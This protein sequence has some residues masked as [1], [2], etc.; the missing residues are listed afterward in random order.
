MMPVSGDPLIYVGV[1]DKA[2][3]ALRPGDGCQVWRQDLD[4]PPSFPIAAQGAVYTT[5]IAGGIHA[6]RRGDG[7]PLWAHQLATEFP[8]PAVYV[9]GH[10]C[11]VTRDST[12]QAFDAA[13]GALVWRQT[14]RDV[15]RA[16]L[17]AQAGHVYVRTR[18][19][20]VAALGARDGVLLWQVALSARGKLLSLAATPTT[21]VVRSHDGQMIAVDADDGAELWRHRD[22]YPGLASPTATAAMIYVTGQ[23]GPRG[24]HATVRAVR[25]DDGEVVWEAHPGT[26][27]LSTAAEIVAGHLYVAAK[28]GGEFMVH[29]LGVDD[30][31]EIWRQ[32]MTAADGGITYPTATTEAVYVGVGRANGLFAVD[33]TDGHP[34]WQALQGTSATAA[35]VG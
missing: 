19:G 3:C 22:G 28:M 7:T 21:L 27:V 32:R 34:L 33:A 30:G 6:W 5:T 26:A 12:V 14:V 2:V 10:V 25:L 8:S 15:E 13:N 23:N 4:A 18:D 35:T 9:G 29:A 24:R 17:V 1:S 31:R 11:V 16:Q 20:A